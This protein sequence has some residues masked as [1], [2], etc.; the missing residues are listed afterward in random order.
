NLGLLGGDHIHDHAAF[1]HLGQTGLNFKRGDLFFHFGQL[2]R[3]GNSKGI[4]PFGFCNLSSRPPPEETTNKTRSSQG[5]QPMTCTPGK[6]LAYTLQS[7][8]LTNK[9]GCQRDWSTSS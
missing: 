3:M 8:T 7:V 4:L 6:S 1:Q 9:G 2:Q 5:L